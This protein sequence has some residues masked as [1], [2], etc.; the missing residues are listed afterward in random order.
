MDSSVE[1]EHLLVSFL[2]YD[3]GN[4]P[5]KPAPR[6]GESLSI[7]VQ[8]LP[9][10]KDLSRSIRNVKHPRYGS[11]VALRRAATEAMDGRAWYF[12]PISL[13]LL[14][15][16]PALH[17]GRRPNDYAGGVSDTVDGSS[18]FTFTYL[19]IVFE[20]DC[21]IV[22]LRATFRRARKTR[23]RLKVKFL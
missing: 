22:H 3:P 11:F 15:L 23:Y 8:G 19:P 13:D 21:Q 14:L 16:A 5:T 10:Y 2:P 1:M 12:G 9:P 4:L 6:R 18:G 7:E 17:K 20:D